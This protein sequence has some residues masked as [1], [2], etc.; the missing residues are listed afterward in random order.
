[1]SRAFALCFFY[2][3]M[4]IHPAVH[5]AGAPASHSLCGRRQHRQ[6][7]RHLQI[8]SSPSRCRSYPSP[9]RSSIRQAPSG[10]RG[11]IADECRSCICNPYLS[12]PSNKKAKAVRVNCLCLF[13]LFPVYI[14]SLSGLEATSTEQNETEHHRTLQS[15]FQ[16]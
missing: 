13:L 14:I 9:H 5:P 3:M 16:V 15:S 6:Q 4:L 11:C 2:W 8:T 1:M 7:L 10:S 12:T